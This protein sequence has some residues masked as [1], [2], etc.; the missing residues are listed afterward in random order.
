MR[1]P[2]R[3][4]LNLTDRGLLRLGELVETENFE[5]VAPLAVEVFVSTE[6]ELW[7]RTEEGFYGR[8]ERSAVACCGDWRGSH[9][10]EIGF[11]RG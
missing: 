1:A 2:Y 9:D 4:E 8:G 6:V 7:V 10:G 5:M 11:K 3:R